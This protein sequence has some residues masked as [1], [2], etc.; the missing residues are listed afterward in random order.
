VGQIKQFKK[1]GLAKPEINK[2]KA[3][4]PEDMAVGQYRI[5]RQQEKKGGGETDDP[6]RKKARYQL[7]RVM[8]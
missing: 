3:G 4:R 2:Y 8:R 6:T 7:I 1:S 5:G